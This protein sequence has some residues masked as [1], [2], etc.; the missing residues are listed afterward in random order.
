MPDSATLGVFV[1]ASLILLVTPGPAVIYIVTRS[2]DQGWIAA[3][4]PRPAAD[5][6]GTVAGQL[7]FLSGVFFALAIITDTTYALLAGE[8]ARPTS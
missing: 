7:L 8:V 4:K 5:S 2:I 6:R 3:W 1:A